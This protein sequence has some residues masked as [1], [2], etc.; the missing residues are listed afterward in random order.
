MNKT[1]LWGLDISLKCTGITIYCIEEKE[2]V[3]I[4]SFNTKKIYATKQYKGLEKNAIKL[5][6][7][8]DWAKPLLLEYPPEEIAIERMFSRFPAE[9][10]AIAKATGV[11]QCLLWTKPQYLYPPKSVKL[12]IVHGDATKEDLANCILTSNEYSHLQFDNEDESDSCAVLITHLIEKEL[13]VWNK[14][15]WADIKK[16]R[17]PK[18]QKKSKKK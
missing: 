17:K 15:V 8:A 11:L 6:K 9:T 13:I 3:Y 4:G 18:E 10:Q 14:P 16:L 2:I 12:A 5:K 7:I 1:F